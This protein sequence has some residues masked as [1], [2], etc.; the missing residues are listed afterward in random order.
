M[1]VDNENKGKKEV[2]LKGKER[3]NKKN[4]GTK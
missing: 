3:H 4:Y 2:V 1:T